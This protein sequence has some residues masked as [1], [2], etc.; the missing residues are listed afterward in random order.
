[1]VCENISIW[2][3]VMVLPDCTKIVFYNKFLQNVCIFIV[4]CVFVNTHVVKLYLNFMCFQWILSYQCFPTT[5]TSHV[6]IGRF[7]KFIPNLCLST[8]NAFFGKHYWMVLRDYAI[9]KRRFAVVIISSKIQGQVIYWINIEQS[10]Q[11]SLSVGL[12]YC[13]VNL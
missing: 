11:F 9:N 1:M 10:F 7:I 6:D 2:P 5:F 12:N 4:I 3:P 13:L 8:A